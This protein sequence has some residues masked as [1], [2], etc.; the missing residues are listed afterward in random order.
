MSPGS[1]QQEAGLVMDPDRSAQQSSN[2][3]AKQRDDA[4]YDAEALRHKL[5][6]LRDAINAR[7]QRTPRARAFLADL[8]GIIND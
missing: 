4:E 5:W 3:L 8:L 1:S 6:R 7:L 2:A